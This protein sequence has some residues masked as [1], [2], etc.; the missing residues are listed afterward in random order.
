MKKSIFFLS[1]LMLISVNVFAQFDDVLKK[2]TEKVTKVE[3]LEEKNVTTSI[4]D[5]LP[6]AFWLKDLSDYDE[7]LEPESYN[8]NLSPG[9]YKFVLQSYCLK[10]GTKGPTKGS[11][12][13]LAPLKGK[14]SDIVYN[15]VTN[16]ANHPEIDQRDIQVFLWGV[17]YGTK[18]TDYPPEFQNKIRPLLTPAEMTDLSLDL[19]N[20]PL[21]AMP[22]DIKK[23]ATFY[24]DF[25]NKLTNPSSTYND[26][27]GMAMLNGV[28]PE[29][30]FSKYIQKGLWAYL[31]DG[32]YGR[33]KPEGYQRTIEEIYRPAKVNATKDS[34]GRLTMLENEGNKI[35]IV[36][37]DEP[38]RDIVS[39]SGQGDYPVWR[40]KSIKLSADNGL[41]ET[42]I[43]NTGW[44]V[45][46]KGLALKKG[47]SNKYEP[48]M[49][50]PMFSDY[51]G[52]VN[53]GKRTLK[54][55]DE[56][57]KEKKMQP[58]KDKQDECWSDYHTMK[59]LKAATNPMDKSG[60]MN[61][62]QKTLKLATD[63]WN[64]ASGALA[65]EENNDNSNKKVDFRK[66]PAVPATNG[67][68]RIISSERRR[69]E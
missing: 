3:L 59:G 20:V 44:M 45:K 47:G 66:F 54:D 13:L 29:D 15:V 26:I 8:F 50:D 22:S 21:D 63:W 41:N 51:S 28:L 46:D 49:D 64:N 60:Q 32:F 36:Y 53:D 18:F 38:G 5:A 9:Y 67:M 6:V 61:W 56:Y 25:R 35:E 30:P 1:F 40:F 7:P 39:F 69:V 43:E 34:K 33:S 31:G 4:E 62:I 68:Q 14:R 52:R 55:F 57:R 27:E 10:A 12:Y 42:T 2:A 48:V 23:V 16:S 19:M 11:G 65:G 37:D 24:H 58:L 17:I